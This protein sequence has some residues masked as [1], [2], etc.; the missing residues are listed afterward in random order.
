MPPQNQAN[1]S[2]TSAAAAFS[3]P[4]K[5][6][7]KAQETKLMQVLDDAMLSSPSTASSISSTSQQNSQPFSSMVPPNILITS[8]EDGDKLGSLT[9]SSGKK[10]NSVKFGG[11]I[12]K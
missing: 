12:T 2:L 5:V 4:L 7:T 6:N 10:L 1:N 3:N 11:Q 9:S 8:S